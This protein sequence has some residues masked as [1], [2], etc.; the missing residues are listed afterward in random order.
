MQVQFREVDTFSLW[1]WFELH[2][3]P[4]EEDLELLDAVLSSWF[5]I[6][7]LGGY[8]TM[9]LQAMY[10]GNETVSFMNYDHEHSDS[11]FQATFHDMGSLEHKGKWC[12]CWFNLGTADELALDVLINALINFSRENVGITHCF[13]GGVNKEWPVPTMQVSVV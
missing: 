1:V 8:N 10:A 11:A 2:Q 4:S 6:G 13:I 5:M 7:R 9:N 3:S 12:R